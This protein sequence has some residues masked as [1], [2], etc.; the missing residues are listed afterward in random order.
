ML[1]PD[2]QMLSPISSFPQTLSLDEDVICDLPVG[3][4]CMCYLILDLIF[5][6]FKLRILGREVLLELRFIGGLFLP[7]Y[8]SL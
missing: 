6:V 1:I 5:F 3:C 4:I 8:R 7:C 2:V